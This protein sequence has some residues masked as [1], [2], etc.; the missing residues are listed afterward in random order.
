V[1]KVF[2]RKKVQE[3]NWWILSAIDVA[4]GYDV[5]DVAEFNIMQLRLILRSEDFK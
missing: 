5:A 1:A 3:C 4:T 2:K